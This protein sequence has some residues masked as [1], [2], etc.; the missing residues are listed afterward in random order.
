LRQGGHRRTGTAGPAVLAPRALAAAVAGL[1]CLAAAGGAQATLGRARDSVEADRASLSAR[2]GSTAAATHTVQA[3]TL[4]N[5]VV[6][7]E[8]V[9]PDGTVFAVTWRGAGRPDLRQLLGD[10]FITLQADNAPRAGRRT[11]A[12]LGVNRPDFKLQSGGHSGA[13]WGVAYLPGL[14]PAGFSF[15]DLAQ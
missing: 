13:F 10:Y 5:G 3:L 12:P 7:R 14:A 8:F 15:R 9:R 2:L 6:A 11:R 4:A 1:A